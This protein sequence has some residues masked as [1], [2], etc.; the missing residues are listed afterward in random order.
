MM[1]FS[2][3]FIFP[4]FLCLGAMCNASIRKGGGDRRGLILE[5]GNSR[6]HAAAATAPSNRMPGIWSSALSSCCWSDSK[7]QRI[8]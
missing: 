3:N 2:R 1:L 4:L 7:S 6:A 5:Q 8:R